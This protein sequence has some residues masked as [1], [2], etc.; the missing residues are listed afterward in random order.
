MLTIHQLSKSFGLEPLFKSISFSLNAGEKA[1]LVG[2]NGCGKTTLL[3]I[4]AGQERADSGSVTLDAPGITL[5]YLPQGFTFSAGETLGGF[6]DRMQGDPLALSQRLEALAAALSRR[7]DQPGLQHEYDSV[8][9][10]LD[11][12]G[13]NAGR[14]P[15]V[16][17]AFNLDHLPSDLPAAA[18][19]G[20][21]KT[22]LALAGVLISN[23]HLLLLD[24]PTNHLDIE[25]LEWLENWLAGFRHAALVVSHDRVFLDHVATRILEMDPQK[26]TLR[27]YE[28]NYS[29]YLEQKAAE[30][31]RAWQ[32]YTDQQEEIARLRRAAA[33]VMEAA[34]FKRGGKGDSGDKFAAGFFANRTKG[35]VA[36]AKHI[37]ARI[38]HLLTDERVDKPR[39]SWQMKIEFGDTAETGRDV[40]VLD[41]LAVGYGE[42]VLLSGLTLTLRSGQRCVL[43]G[44]NGCGKTTLLRTAAGLIPPLGGRVRLGSNVH[45]GYMAQ[46][47]ENL[48]PA[49]TPL[50]TLYKV[51]AFGQTEAR[52]FLSKFLFKGDDVF[53]PVKQLSYGERARLSLA[54][55]VAQGCNFL[56]LDEPIN[57]LDIPARARFEQAL[58]GF[59]G[60]ILAVVHD[61]YFIEGFASQLWEV[62]DGRII[63]VMRD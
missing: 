46:E 55:L 63:Q 28:G 13:D 54:V 35:T 3:R 23:P 19:S 11:R 58:A 24:E 12:V 9:S 6:I 29:D 25:M 10:R 16:L 45:L 50:T 22:R 32:D 4:I 42:N 52:S 56:M 48:D 30:H 27:C 60:T 34:S 20:G 36:R 15:E 57:H 39:P 38:D 61:R 1:G 7:P 41:D 40:L 53:T 21:Q 5:G 37:E 43:V 2:P 33:H 62:H 14:A 49:L 59:E 47:Q 17:A 18:L 51:S 44:P 31:D 8:L 26:N